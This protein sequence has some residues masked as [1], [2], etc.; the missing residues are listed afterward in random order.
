VPRKRALVAVHAGAPTPLSSLR[1]TFLGQLKD[2]RDRI[3]TAISAV[4]AL[5]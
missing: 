5:G 2:A 4:E 1:I 3:D